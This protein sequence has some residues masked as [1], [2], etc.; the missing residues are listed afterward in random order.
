MLLSGARLSVAQILNDSVKQVYG[1]HTTF[2]VTEEDVFENKKPEIVDDKSVDKN[3]NEGHSLDTNVHNMQNYGFLYR[4]DN[5]YQDLGMLTTPLSPIF[6]KAPTQIGKTFG[7]NSY[8]PYAF[9]PNKIKYYN[10]RS[11]YSLLEYVQGNLGQQIL[12]AEFSR[13]IKPNWNFGID[14]RTM[15][16]LKSIGLHRQL[17]F[18]NSTRDLQGK[19]FSFA[20]HTRYFTKDSLY[21][22]LANF[23]FFDNQN[24]ETGGIVPVQDTKDSSNFGYKVNN[25]RLLAAR[26]LERR[27]NYHVYQQYTLSGDKLQL[28]HIVDYHNQTDRFTDGLNGVTD[29]MNPNGLML[30]PVR[31]DTAGT[32]SSAAIRLLENKAGVKGSSGKWT[33]RAYY[34]RKDFSYTLNYSAAH[35]PIKNTFSENFVGGYTAYKTGYYSQ[36]SAAGEYFFAGHNSDSLGNNRGDYSL[37]LDYTAKNLSIGYTSMYYSPTLMQREYISN[38]QII[39]WNNK[40]TQ[41]RSNTL[42]AKLDI[43]LGKVLA[44]HP[45]VSNT[46]LYNYV[47]YNTEAVPQQDAAL[48]QIFSPELT[49]EFKVG[50]FHLD[51]YYKFTHVSGPGAANINMPKNFDWLKF[52]YQSI[53][54]HN[55]LV[56]QLGV[57]VFYRDKYYTNFYMPVTQQ[58]YLNN[59]TNSNSSYLVSNLFFNLKI[60]TV[61]A[62]IKFSN[63]NQLMQPNKGYYITPYYPIMPFT[64]EFG[65]K[66]MFFD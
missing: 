21:Q 33:Y 56:M 25:I 50:K 65:L 6:Y 23:T 17:A 62:F 5:V 28:F 36:L 22:V 66:W 40:F 29:V 41:T 13:N 26:S 8:S 27:V 24:Y 61:I 32:N 55:A 43:K 60:K 52:Y 7:F 45:A 12:R 16:A 53:L 15:T 37:K 18:L 3:V 9:D 31:Y 30:L 48:I 34:R 59:T 63:L 19:N 35:S 57:E 54:F 46:W 38:Y 4:S 42:N 2:F 47:F 14:F 51:N 49:F 11:P 58:F 39:H 44:L 1:H 20:F 10:T 64:F